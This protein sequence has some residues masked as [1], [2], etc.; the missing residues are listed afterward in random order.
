MNDLILQVGLI[1][2]KSAV[3][4]FHFRVSRKQQQALIHL[5]EQGRGSTRRIE[6]SSALEKAVDEIVASVS[7]KNQQEK[8]TQ[9]VESQ[10]GR[11][12]GHHI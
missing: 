2:T 9:A 8:S 6:V 12:Y 10:K 5:M 11:D 7:L 4:G 3:V 1:A